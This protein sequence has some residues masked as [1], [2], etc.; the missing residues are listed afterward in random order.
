M[1]SWGGFAP[2]LSC[3]LSS[4]TTLDTTSGTST[5]TMPPEQPWTV[6]GM[7]N[8]T[9]IAHAMRELAALLPVA[10]PD[11]TPAPTPEVLHPVRVGGVLGVYLSNYEVRVQVSATVLV[12]AAMTGMVVG[13]ETNEVHHHGPDQP[14]TLHYAAWFLNLLPESKFRV[15]V[16]ACEEVGGSR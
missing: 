5:S 2:D 12:D 7:D 3:V 9:R 8:T 16:T 6:P 1:K 4:M 11:D 10:F 14:A 15:K 13:V